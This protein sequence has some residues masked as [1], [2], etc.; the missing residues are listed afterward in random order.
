M[1]ITP[2]LVLISVGVFSHLARAEMPAIT[3]SN[4]GGA[5]PATA[6]EPATTSSPSQSEPTTKQIIDAAFPFV[7]HYSSQP[8]S[9]SSAEK[10]P[11]VAVVPSRVKDSSRIVFSMT[12]SAAFSYDS[13]YQALGFPSVGFR[14]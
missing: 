14:F 3:P 5:E 4:P 8:G 11:S 2:L 10:N 9:P 6:P 13:H 12:P 7:A 1:K